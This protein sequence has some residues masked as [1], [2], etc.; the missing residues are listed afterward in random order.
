MWSA[1]KK[2]QRALRIMAKGIDP[3]WG[4]RKVSEE[5]PVEMRFRCAE[6]G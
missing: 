3:G 4:S 6:V 1:V 2:K 5:D